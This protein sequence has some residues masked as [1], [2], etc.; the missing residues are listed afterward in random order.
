M[1]F[2]RSQFQKIN[3]S[4][5]GNQKPEEIKLNIKIYPNPTSNLVTISV[6]DS[7]QYVFELR[8]IYNRICIQKKNNK[9]IDVSTLSNGIYAVRILVSNKMQYSGKLVIIK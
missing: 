1:S 9:E 8:D 7:I 3:R 5:R 2:T 4:G 6:P